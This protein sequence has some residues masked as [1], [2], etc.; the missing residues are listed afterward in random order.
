MNRVALITDLAVLQEQRVLWERLLAQT[1]NASFF[2]SLDWLLVYWKHFGGNQCLRVLVV[3]SD[4]QAVGILPLVVRTRRQGP[5]TSK[6]LTYPLDDWGTCYG[7]IGPDPAQTIK[8]AMGHLA[9][10]PRD[11]DYLE[12]GW[13][14]AGAASAQT[15]AAMRSAGLG[16]V[17]TTRD[18]VA[19]VDLKGTWTEYLAS[20]GHKWRVNFR[21]SERKLAELGR[22][23][24]VRH[25]PRPA[26]AGDGDPRWDLY[27][28]CQRVAARSW[29]AARHDGTTL[30]HPQVCPFLRQAHAAA[31]RLGMVDINLL[32]LNGQPVAFAYNYVSDGRLFGLRRGHDTTISSG[33]GSV[34]L[35]RTMEDSFARGDRIF[36]LGAGYL[37]AKRHWQT[38][39]IRTET[40]CHYPLT[41]P[42]AQ[43]VRLARALRGFRR[44]DVSK[45]AVAAG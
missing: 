8:F 21:R 4:G 25:R 27:D 11:W 6:V 9:G 23:E 32:Y 12:L 19:L 10:E 5:A 22:V 13:T 38:C 17:T 7:P 35:G 44:R 18:T 37:D 40:I 30:S 14:P 43:G 26:K 20:R 42:K 3:Y 29:Q 36:N 34:L 39:T 33:A 1:E 41:S 16:C 31:A 28:D 15:S 2:Q 24:Y 45:S